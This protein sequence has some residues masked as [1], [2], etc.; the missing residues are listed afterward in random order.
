M[1]AL[2]VM[3]NGKRICIAGSEDLCVL[4]ASVAAAGKLGNKTVLQRSDETFQVFYQV[5]GLT[6]RK[7]PQM[8]VHM[9]WK[10]V[11]P[12]EVGDVIQVKIIDTPKADRPVSRKRA[13]P[14]SKTKVSKKNTVKKTVTKGG[15]KGKKKTKDT[16]RN[17]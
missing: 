4:N 14:I 13:K 15:G 6:R 16:V 11:A 3:L 17:G 12:L 9:R 8:D 7:N 1:I 2:E 5:G 10:S